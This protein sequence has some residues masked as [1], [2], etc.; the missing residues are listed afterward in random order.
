MQNNTSPKRAG[1]KKSND[2]GKKKFTTIYELAMNTGEKKCTLQAYQ[3]IVVDGNDGDGARSQHLGQ[4][5]GVVAEALY[6][7]REFGA[8]RQL[9]VCVLVKGCLLLR[10]VGVVALQTQYVSASTRMENKVIRKRRCTSS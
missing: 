5:E 2:E 4:A 9:R 3:H 6:N 10:A 8:Q 1:S 7:E